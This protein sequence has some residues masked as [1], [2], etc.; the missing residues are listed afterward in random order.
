MK[1]FALVDCN[2]FYVSCE[3]VFNPALIGK[4]VVVLSNNDGCIIARSEEAKAIGIPM[5]APLFK[6]KNILQKK[7]VLIYSSNYTLYGDMSA[8]VMNVLRQFTE[9]IEIY[10]IDEA[11]L[12]FDVSDVKDLHSLIL[13]MREVTYKW[14]GIPV[15]VGLGPT[16][17]LAK[18][19]NSIAKKYFVNGIYNIT[20][21]A[22][23]SSILNDT[24]VENIWGISKRWGLRLRSIGVSTAQELKCSDPRQIRYCIS[25]VGERIVRELNGISCLSLETVSPRKSIMVS[26][27]FGNL[28]EDQKSLIEAVSNHVTTAAFKLRKQNSFANGIYVFIQTNYFKKNMPQ[29]KNSISLNFDEPSQDTAFIIRKASEAL[30]KIYRTGFMYNKAGIILI[31]LVNAKNES[32]IKSIVS[33]QPNLFASSLDKEKDKIK[34]DL[35]MITI[36]KINNKMGSNTIYYGVQGHTK[37]TKKSWSMQSHYRSPYYTTRWDDLLEVL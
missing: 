11:F 10:S 30:K 28:L 12:V 1:I 9:N 37:N 26:R 15:S 5:G 13:E 7:K 14:T 6:Y 29:Y 34:I 32:N 16:K 17:T 8:R 36:D 20:D 27:S 2:N 33:F 35:R 19:A 23:L 4:P 25:V 18:L 22:K 24:P 31:G 3:R 21:S